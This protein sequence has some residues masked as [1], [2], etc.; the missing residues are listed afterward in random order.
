MVSRKVP[1]NLSN[2]TEVSLVRSSAAE[3]LTFIASSGQGGVALPFVT[4]DVVTVASLREAGNGGEVGADGADRVER[5]ALAQL[6]RGEGN[7]GKTAAIG[8]DKKQTPC[9]GRGHCRSVRV[10]AIR[11]MRRLGFRGRSRYRYRG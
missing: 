11:E 2:K 6:A 1:P 4:G 10:A 8:A 7:D 5:P 3:Y 9:K